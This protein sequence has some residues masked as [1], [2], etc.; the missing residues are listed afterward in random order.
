VLYVSHVTAAQA[1]RAVAAVRDLPVLT[2]SDAEGFSEVGGIAQFFFEHGQLRF[3]V[4][5]TC[6]KRARLRI[7]SR[8][9]I[10]RRQK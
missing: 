1:A 7:S 3:S 10:L 8:L 6:A 9:L 2:I 4:E 5:L